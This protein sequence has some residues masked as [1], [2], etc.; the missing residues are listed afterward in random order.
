MAHACRRLFENR[1]LNDVA[2]RLL[3]TESLMHY[4]SA[5]SR[6]RPNVYDINRVCATCQSSYTVK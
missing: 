2:Q 4:Y 3:A 6:S 5:V 1:V